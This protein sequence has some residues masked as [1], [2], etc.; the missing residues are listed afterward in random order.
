RAL[1][2]RAMPHARHEKQA[3]PLLERYIRIV[4][5]EPLVVLHRV[6]RGEPRIAHA[7]HENQLATRVAEAAEVRPRIRIAH[8]GARIHGLFPFLLDVLRGAYGPAFRN[9]RTRENAR[10][11]LRRRDTRVVVIAWVHL[12]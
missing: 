11:P 3:A 8:H 2:A 1:A 4:A 9:V 10:K 12:A 5:S 7:M 6:L